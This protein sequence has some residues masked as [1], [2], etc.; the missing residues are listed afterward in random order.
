MIKYLTILL[1]VI[2]YT[3]STAAV[4]VDTTAILDKAKM[5]CV[6]E[7]GLEEFED[8][9][10]IL[11]NR[12]AHLDTFDA[13]YKRSFVGHEST[14]FMLIKIIELQPQ[15]KLEYILMYDILNRRFIKLR[16]FDTYHPKSIRY[17]LKYINLDTEYEGSFVKEL[18][19][20]KYCTSYLKLMLHSRKLPKSNN[21]IRREFMD[22]VRIP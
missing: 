6:A 8:N 9:D 10:S 22:V 11:A 13:W 21:E 4:G 16:G 1:F 15:L 19:H 14:R 5:L 7:Q 2:L 3:S 12:V 17:A 20:L 18:R